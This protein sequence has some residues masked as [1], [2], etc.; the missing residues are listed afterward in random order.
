MILAGSLGCVMAVGSASRIRWH[1]AGTRRWHALAAVVLL[2]VLPTQLLADAKLRPEAVAAF[3][4]YAETVHKQFSS[5]I[6]GRESFLWSMSDAA[7]SRALFNGEVV[8][9][10]MEDAGGIKV[11]GGLIHDWVA[12]VLVPDAEVAD[13]VGVVTNYDSHEITYSSSI[14]RSHVIEQDGSKYHVAM[15]LQHKAL[16]TVVL[17]AEHRAEYARLD[18]QRWWGRSRAVRVQEV[19]NPG[20]PG[21]SLRP[22][23]DD[24]GVLWRLHAYWLFAEID[25]A[26]VAEY[27]T[28]S[29]TRSVPSGLGWMLRPLIPRRARASFRNVML[30]TRDKAQAQEQ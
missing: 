30:V 25:T 7:R 26:V 24:S 27:R 10:P 22:A 18:D 9:E 3:D 11:P 23:G 8:I 20:K 16:R 19:R 29:L 21:E 2:A 28:I 5:R 17:D 13:V 1:L 12:A 15:R 14:L 6:D 4:Q